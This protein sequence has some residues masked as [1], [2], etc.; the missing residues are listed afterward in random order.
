[1]LLRPCFSDHAFYNELLCRDSEVPAVEAEDK[2]E[3]KLG[4]AGPNADLPVLELIRQVQN[5][6][7]LDGLPVL[8][9]DRY[10]DLDKSE[11]EG[12]KC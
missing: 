12:S 9:M 8:V 1:M 10:D 3:A 7:H 4:C 5:A 2:L 6:T 11:R